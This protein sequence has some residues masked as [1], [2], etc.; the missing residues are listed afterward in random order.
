MEGGGACWDLTSFQMHLC[1][2]EVQ[3]LYPHGVF[4]RT[5]VDNPYSDFTTINIA[6]CSGDLHAG[7][8]DR[9][10]WL[11]DGQPTVQ[12]G[13]ANAESAVAWALEHLGGDTLSS[14]VL[15]GGSAGAMGA[16]VWSNVLLAQFKYEKA[17]V[18]PDSYIGVFPPPDVAGALVRDA[19]FCHSS[20][21]EDEGFKQICYSGKLTVQDVYLHAMR[22]FPAVQFTSVD[23]VKDF[24][25]MAFYDAMAYSYGVPN[26]APVESTTFVSKLE[27]IEA[28]YKESVTNFQDFNIDSH[29]HMYTN[30]HRFYTATNANGERLPAWLAQFS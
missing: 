27:E 9:P 15:M 3:G 26:E 6:Y 28:H 17:V 22:T 1:T 10:N 25:Q 4:S 8:M 29:Q 13:Y 14:F 30:E 12:R 11:R 2:D 24:V 23:S 7:N 5:H 19:G 20:I 21:F 16:Q 18:V